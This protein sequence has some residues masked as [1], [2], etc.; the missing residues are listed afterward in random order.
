M[1]ICCSIRLTHDLGV[2]GEDVCGDGMSGVLRLG[3][4]SRWVRCW[5]LGRR[6]GGLRRR[7]EHC[8]DGT[9]ESIGHLLLKSFLL[10]LDNLVKVILVSS[11]VRLLLAIETLRFK[12][13]LLEVC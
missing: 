1:N 12:T 7:A 13:F 4:R 11:D 6:D 5:R 8:V 10:F 2:S 3:T 9:K